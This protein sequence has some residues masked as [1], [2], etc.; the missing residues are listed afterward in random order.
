MLVKHSIIHNSRISWYNE[1]ESSWLNTLK[2]LKRYIKIN[3]SLPTSNRNKELKVWV[4]TQKYNYKSRRYI[5]KY[6]K[7]RN[8]WLDFIT[9]YNKYFNDIDY[10]WLNK[11]KEIKEYIEYYKTRPINNE[12]EEWIKEQ[13]YNYTNDLMDEVMKNE[14]VR[15]NI[16]FELYLLNERFIVSV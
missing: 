8:Y 11:L 3:K 14:W 6:E 9:E 7:I 1:L 10:I 5:M 4:K 16:G 2:S 12:L 13:E 15:Y